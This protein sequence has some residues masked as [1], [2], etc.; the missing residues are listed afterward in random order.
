MR[1]RVNY[2]KSGVMIVIKMRYDTSNLRLMML[3]D[4]IRYATLLSRPFTKMPR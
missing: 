3:R 1:E 4:T 2:D